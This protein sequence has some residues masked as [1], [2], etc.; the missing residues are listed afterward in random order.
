MRKHFLILTLFCFLLMQTNAQSQQSLLWKISG[1]GLQQPSYIFGTFH[2]LCAKDI[3]ITDT[4]KSIIHHSQQV[5]FEIKMDD[6]DLTKKTLQ[7]VSMKD[8]HQLKEF[9]PAKDYSAIDSIFKSKT[10]IS[11][12]LLSNYKPYLLVP[13]LYQSMLGCA[14]VGLE[15]ELQKIAKI[16]SLPIY[17]L[18]TLE[19]QM[20]IFDSIDY[21]I[22][23]KELSKNVLHFEESR[24]ELL[25]MIKVY[26]SKDINAMQ[27]LV[28]EDDTFGKYDELLLNQRNVNWIPIIINQVKLKSTFIAVGAGH[29]GGTKGILHLLIDKGFTITPVVY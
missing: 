28:K 2:L 5:F 21:N 27:E 29:L 14:P 19:Y 24:K 9:I 17:G 6:P 4:L 15:G 8:G 1:N 10:Q 12:S 22:Q 18:E 23:A 3:N 20:K 26:Q 7:S 11:I 16:D 25:Q 13:L